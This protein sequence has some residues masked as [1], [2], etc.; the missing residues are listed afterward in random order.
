MDIEI[1]KPTNS[2]TVESRS[3]GSG[4]SS[5][6]DDVITSVPFP[7]EKDVESGLRI[8]ELVLALTAGELHHQYHTGGKGEY[9]YGPGGYYFLGRSLLS[10]HLTV[11]Q[12][13]DTIGSWLQ[14]E[15]SAG[16]LMH[17][18]LR[19]IGLISDNVFSPAAYFI[20]IQLAPL[21]DALLAEGQVDENLELAVDLKV[22]SLLKGNWGLS[23]LL[24]TSSPEQL[25]GSLF[26]ATITEK[27]AWLVRLQSGEKKSLDPLPVDAATYV[28]DGWLGIPTE[29]RYFPPQGVQWLMS[30]YVEHLE[31]ACPGV[32]ALYLKSRSSIAAH[33]R[34][35]STPSN[36]VSS[37]ASSIPTPREE[38][39]KSRD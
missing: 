10:M 8:C 22:S 11:R 35:Q 7:K 14:P 2:I 1:V 25:T 26:G 27:V 15:V 28:L 3:G 19:A 12:I 30:N 5:L 16:S 6:G 24:E 33:S 39:S 13:D 37:I 36:R 29:S 21:E 4:E 23:Q 31:Q 34:S 18:W 20:L 17:L 32:R 9:G 38:R